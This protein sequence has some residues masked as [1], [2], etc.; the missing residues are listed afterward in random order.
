[1]NNR[2]K[3]ITFMKGY[4]VQTIIGND[5]RTDQS[6]PVINREIPA[7]GTGNMTEAEATAIDRDGWT[8]VKQPH[9]ADLRAPV[10]IMG[11]VEARPSFGSIGRVHLGRHTF[12]LNAPMQSSRL[13]L[14][15]EDA[16]HPLST[17]EAHGV[18]NQPNATPHTT[19]EE[20]HAIFDRSLSRR[21]LSTEGSLHRRGRQIRDAYAFVKAKGA[22]LNHKALKST[23]NE[24]ARHTSTSEPRA[25][26]DPARL[27][28]DDGVT[29]E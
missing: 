3:G 8:P 18:I 23:G 10:L 27:I 15:K 28:S 12:D 1:M 25:S 21:G 6:S 19:P 22:D 20:I 7:Q 17:V 2:Y 11:Q 4:E 26:I 16:P 9:R 24:N 29:W 5:L 13:V 14:W